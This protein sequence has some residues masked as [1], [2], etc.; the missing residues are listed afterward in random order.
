V[1]Y[2]CC[3]QKK[4]FRTRFSNRV[5]VSNQ[6]NKN[7]KQQIQ[8]FHPKRA[9]IIVTKLDIELTKIIVYLQLIAILQSNLRD[10]IKSNWEILD[11][12]PLVHIKIH[13]L[14]AFLAIR[15]YEKTKYELSSSVCNNKNT[16]TW[17]WAMWCIHSV[18][19]FTTSI[20]KKKFYNIKANDSFKK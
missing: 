10:K 13:K 14:Q 1:T 18:H 11:S 8:I 2:C 5:S 19:F 3:L 20:S 12:S 9:M 6:L 4:T 16:T 7:T 15:Q 17:D